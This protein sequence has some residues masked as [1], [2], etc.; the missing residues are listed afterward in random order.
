MSKTP[1]QPKMQHCAYCG[2]EIGVYVKYYNDP[3]TC[4]ATECERYVREEAQAARDEAH[5]QLDRDLGY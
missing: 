3:D 5:E 4:G 1:K 2:S